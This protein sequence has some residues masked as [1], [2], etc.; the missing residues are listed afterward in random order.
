MDIIIG[1]HR[2]LSKDVRFADLGLVIIDEEQ[3]FGVEHK[4]RHKKRGSGA[5]EQSRLSTA[6]KKGDISE[7]QEILQIHGKFTPLNLL[8]VDRLKALTQEFQGDNTVS[9]RAQIVNL[10]KSL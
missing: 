1:T 7:A 9:K 4:H 5:R 2:L 3:R 6:S 10:S 8:E